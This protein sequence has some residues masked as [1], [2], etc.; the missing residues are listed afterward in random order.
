Q[1]AIAT[2]PLGAIKEI[3][4][5][6]NA[7]SSEFGWT[8]GPALNIVTKSGTNSLHGEALFLGRPGGSQAKSFSTDGFCPDS[9][10][11]CVTPDTL[12]AISPVDIPDKLSQVSGSIGGPIVK[13]KTFFFLTA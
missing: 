6:T 11:G 5:L 1:T 8:S 12:G 3:Q 9:T 4:V 7:F 2:V 10:P 13:D